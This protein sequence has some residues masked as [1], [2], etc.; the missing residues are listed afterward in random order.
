[1]YVLAMWD[2]LDYTGTVKCEKTTDP[3]IIFLI[4]LPGEL[5]TIRMMTLANQMIVT[6]RTAWLCDKL[7]A[8]TA[9][10]RQAWISIVGL[11]SWLVPRPPTYV[12]V[13]Y[14]LR[15]SITSG[16]RFRYRPI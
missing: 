2:P 14:S 13:I 1:M 5:G 7:F 16:E 10:T 11:L 9:V 12:C 6:N 4:V 15:M 8:H 3:Q